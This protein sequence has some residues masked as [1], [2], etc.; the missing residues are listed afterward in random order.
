M[1]A[2]EPGRNDRGDEELGA[3]GVLASVGH[4]EDT[5]L[6]VLQLEV[7]I[8]IVPIST[9]NRQRR[10][11]ATLTLELL[12]VD[13]LSTGTVTAGEV[14]TLEHEVGDDTVE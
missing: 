4:R 10:I 1:S 7:L 9:S 11:T 14:A 6:G 8:W 13:R 3:V 12:A 2:V 5:G